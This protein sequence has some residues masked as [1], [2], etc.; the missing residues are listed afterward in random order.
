[1]KEGSGE[2]MFYPD[3]SGH[4]W[5]TTM[6][7]VRTPPAAAMLPS[8]QVSSCRELVVY[9]YPGEGCNQAVR[10]SIYNS[11]GCSLPVLVHSLA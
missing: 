3:H 6:G 7:C 11:R 9:P 8:G 5:H 2:L 4:P 1:M 10:L